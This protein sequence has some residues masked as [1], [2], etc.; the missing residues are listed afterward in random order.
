MRLD[1]IGFYTL[2][3]SRAMDASWRSPLSR[4]EL[5]LT[6]RCNLKCLYCTNDKTKKPMSIYDARGVVLE[7]ALSGLKNIRFSG[8]EPTLWRG[9]CDL[10]KYTKELG[11]ERVAVSSNGSADIG[12]YKELISLGVDDFSISLDSCCSSTGNKM[13]GGKN[14]W[15]KVTENIRELSSLVY[16][17]VGVVITDSNKSE[18]ADI[19]GFAS[20]D[21]GVSDI[22]LITASQ[23]ESKYLCDVDIN[24]RTLAKHPILRYR[25]N[26]M[27][28][29]VPLRGLGDNDPDS[30]GLVLDDMLVAN[31]HHFPC[32]IYYRQGGGPIGEVGYNMRRD[33][34]SWFLD[35]R[36]QN[37]EICSGNCLDVCVAYNKKYMEDYE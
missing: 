30:C 8:G 2:Y 22:R 19:V 29:G 16:L 28:K 12:L 11:V 33:R 26:N 31:G 17:S 34:L 20:N 35:H 4:C 1:D 15:D 37:D 5:I 21:L 18:I 6:N 27:R 36:P 25:I 23:T 32:V 13:A 14:V 10:V 3:D 9:L 7:W 24:E